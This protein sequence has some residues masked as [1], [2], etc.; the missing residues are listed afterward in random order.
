MRTFRASQ[1]HIEFTSVE[2]GDGILLRSGRFPEA[3]LNDVAG[4]LRSKRK[5]KTPVHMRAAIGRE[6]IRRQD[7]Q[8]FKVGE[9]REV[10]E[11]G[12][13]GE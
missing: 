1:P 9:N 2:R 4:C 6:V 10:I 11:R 13:V 3:D 7:T 8:E 12:A 5:S